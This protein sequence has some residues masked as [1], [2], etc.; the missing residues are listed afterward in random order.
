MI[1]QYL[2]STK[3]FGTIMWPYGFDLNLYMD[4]DFVSLLSREPYENPDAVWSPTGLILLFCS[5]PLLWKSFLQ[6]ELSMPM[7]ETKY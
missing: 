6:T 3:L 7:V 2:V 4:A 1:I 5:Y